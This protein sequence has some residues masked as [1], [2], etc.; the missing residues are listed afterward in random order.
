MR[1]LYSRAKLACEPAGAA[2]VAAILAG[3]VAL[4]DGPTVAVVS[5]GNADP[6]IV[7][8]PGQPM[9]AD[10][11]PDY[12]LAH[13]TCSCGNEFWTRS[14]KEGSTCRSA[15][16]ATRSIRGS[17]SSSTPAVGWSASSA[18]S[19]RPARPAATTVSPMAVSY[20][21]QAVL[22]AA[23][24]ALHPTAGVDELLLPRIERVALG[25]DL[26]VEP[27]ERVQNSFPHEHVTC[28]RT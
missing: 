28:A 5:G 22:E 9:K 13:V 23:L 20:G 10:I 8:G 21:G 12:V 1:F 27:V 11:H 26:D 18:A 19:R 24:E 3:K 7:A 2:A 4:E 6:K 25:A 16:S 17:R 15:P 14:T